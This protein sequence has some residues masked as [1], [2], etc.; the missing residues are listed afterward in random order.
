MKNIIFY[1]LIAIFAFFLT[2]CSPSSSKEITSIRVMAAASLTEV[3]QDL[4]SNFEKEHPDIEIEL[5][6]AGSQALYS[7]ISYGVAADIFASANLKYIN[8]L[9]EDQQIRDSYIFA[10]NGLVVLVSDLR[11]RELDDLLKDDVNIIIADQSV[12]IGEYTI[13]LLE[14]LNQNPELRVNYK[15]LFLNNVVSKEFSVSEIAT[16]VQIGEADAGV[17]YWSDYFS[18]RDEELSFIEFDKEDN[19]KTTYKVSLLN[20]KSLSNN[21]VKKEA[22]ESF[23][24]FLLSDQGKEILLEHAF[25]VKGP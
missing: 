3:F 5:N 15:E 9:E 19:I 22:A 18:I 4:K 25:L 17:V 11:L 13:Y 12:P 24:Y 6:F 8:L 21:L 2:A 10:N 16:K 23:V 14:N 7:Q 1:T 20:N